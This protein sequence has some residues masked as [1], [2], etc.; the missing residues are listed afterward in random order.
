MSDLTIIRAASHRPL[1]QSGHVHV[2]LTASRATLAKRRWRGVAE[3]GREF[4]FDLD[5]PLHHG[6]HFLI[7]GQAHY[8][9]EQEREEVLE[10]PVNSIEQ[11]ARVAWSL[12]NLHFGVQV[13]P[14]SVRVTP[15]PAVQQM[16]AREQI[17]FQRVSCVFL[18]LSAGAHHHHAHD[19]GHHHE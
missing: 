3:D 4:G 11:A 12:G 1:H 13:L 7:E 16:L 2:R 9:I 15:D 19:H 18:P 10:I 8:L 17:S 14:Q 5:A 6:D